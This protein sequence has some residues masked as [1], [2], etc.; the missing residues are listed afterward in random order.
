MWFSGLNSVVVIVAKYLVHIV[1]VMETQRW[2]LDVDIL[3]LGNYGH[4]KYT[5]M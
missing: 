5:F 4:S 3:Q 2:R 1:H